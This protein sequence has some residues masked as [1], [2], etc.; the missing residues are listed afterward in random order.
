MALTATTAAALIN[1]LEDV[2]E[3]T[4]TDACAIICEAKALICANPAL[5]PQCAEITALA[6]EYAC[7]CPGD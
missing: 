5:G 4:G 3:Q 7:E 2:A 6:K 1:V